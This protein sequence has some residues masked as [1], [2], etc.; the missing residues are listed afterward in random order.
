MN[1]FNL[2]DHAINDNHHY[3]ESFLNI[4]D[5][6]IREFVSGELTEKPAKRLFITLYIG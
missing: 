6:R 4:R 2:R 1:I 3:V 5:E